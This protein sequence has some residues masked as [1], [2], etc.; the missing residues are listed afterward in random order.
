M[1]TVDEG[2]VKPTLDTLPAGL[3]A[4]FHISSH[5]TVLQSLQTSAGPAW[6]RLYQIPTREEKTKWGEG[7]KT[8]SW[9]CQHPILKMRCK[10]KNKN[11]SGVEFE[12]NHTNH[13]HHSTTHIIAPRKDRAA[14]CRDASS[15]V[16]MDTRPRLSGVIC[17]E[18]LTSWSDGWCRGLLRPRKRERQSLFHKFKCQIGKSEYYRQE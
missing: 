12:N 2:I 17:G 1:R 8:W 5:T 3:W 4:E 15:C 9:T 18:C 7:K 14:F 11:V 16:T 10:A 13:S 6:K